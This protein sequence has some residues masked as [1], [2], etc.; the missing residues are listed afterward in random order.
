MVD[1]LRQALDVA[2]EAALEAGRMLREEFHRPGGPRGGGSHA[3]VDEEAECVIRQ[4]SAG[5]VSH[6]VLL[7][8]GDRSRRPGRGGCRPGW[9]T[10][11]MAPPPF[12]NGQRGNCVS[13]ALVD[14]GIPV[15]GVCYAPVYPDDEGDLVTWAE[16]CGP[17]R[18]N[19]VELPPRAWASAVEAS[20]VILVSQSADRKISGNLSCAAPARVRSM[21]SIAWRLALVA[22]GEGEVAVSLNHPN[23]YDYAAGLALVRGAGG[24]AH[25]GARDLSRLRIGGTS[26]VV[27]AGRGRRG[28]SPGGTKLE[29]VPAA[30][31][32]GRGGSPS[33]CCASGGGR[34]I[35]TEVLRRAQGCLLGQL[36]GDSLGGLVEFQGA[37]AIARQYPDGPRLLADGGT[38]DLM[39]GQATDGLGDGVVAGSERGGARRV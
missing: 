38:F 10:P 2:T 24:V 20:L 33:P 11:M 36:A 21:P 4:R 31:A 8:R 37:D 34:R 22:C 18:R 1:S 27:F 15:L 12:L 17:V 5:C 29:H 23:D 16:G 13:I 32:H 14:G 6:L 3:D 7:G 19:G 39:A 25:G 28:G 26:P 30:P 35:P 9:S